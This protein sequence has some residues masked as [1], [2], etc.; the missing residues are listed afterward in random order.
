MTDRVNLLAGLVALGIVGF[1]VLTSTGHASEGY[2]LLAA[3]PALGAVVIGTQV[4]TA[5]E[6]IGLGQLGVANQ[7]DEFK[8][9][10]VAVQAQL[11]ENTNHLGA[12]RN[13]ELVAKVTDGVKAGLADYLTSGIVEEPFRPTTTDTV[14]TGVVPLITPPLPPG[15]MP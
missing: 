2:G 15:L 7:L 4:K 9:Q 14:S 8:T 3:I 1:V 10:L 5:S 12:L 13:G 6:N 11:D